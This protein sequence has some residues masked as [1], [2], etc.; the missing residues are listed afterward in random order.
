MAGKRKYI[1]RRYGKKKKSYHHRRRTSPWTSAKLN[2]FPR[3]TRRTLRYQQEV[4]LNPGTGGS[5]TTFR[6]N[7]LFDPY[8]P[9]GG[10]QPR[11]FDQMMQFYAQYCVMRTKMTC[12]FVWSG[13]ANVACHVGIALRSTPTEQMAQPIDILENPRR[14]VKVL[15][16][17]V[18]NSRTVTYTWNAKKYF[19]V[20]NPQDNEEM[21]GTVTT[22]PK[23]LAYLNP[24]V[25]PVNPF[26]D[27]NVVSI[28][29]L[30]EYDVLFMEPDETSSSLLMLPESGKVLPQS[31]APQI[32][33]KPESMAD[34]EEYETI[35]VRKGSIQPTQ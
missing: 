9:L 17:D 15:P 10:H 4:E 22:D 26:V 13:S 11:G 29:T 34:E 14:V 7:G 3:I 1:P 6:G 32:H 28:S 25:I 35:R 18:E 21:R 24:F 27:P 2:P 5:H 19:G 30:I 12:E 23:E 8:Q 33:V 20:S 31:K 16:A